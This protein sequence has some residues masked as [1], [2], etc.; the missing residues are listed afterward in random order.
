MLQKQA[1]KILKKRRQFANMLAAIT[2]G[3]LQI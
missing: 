1:K 3:Q 2:F